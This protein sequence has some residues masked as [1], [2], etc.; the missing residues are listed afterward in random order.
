LVL[1]LLEIGLHFLAE[2]PTFLTVVFSLAGV[3]LNFFDQ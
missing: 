3:I 2:W 1:L